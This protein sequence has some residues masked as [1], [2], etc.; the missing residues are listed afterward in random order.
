MS[1]LLILTLQLLLVDLVTL[2]LGH[3]ALVIQ[4]GY[5]AVDLWTEIVVVLEELELT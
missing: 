5:G 1:K 2:Y 3:N 4:V